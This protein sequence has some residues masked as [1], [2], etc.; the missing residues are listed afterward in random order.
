VSLLLVDGIDRKEDT[1][2][3]TGVSNE[4]T[5][6]EVLKESFFGEELNESFAT[7]THKNSWMRNSIKVSSNRYLMKGSLMMNSTKVSW[8]HIL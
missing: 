7:G 5:R 1:E 3:N 4:V 6:V 2:Y 8:S